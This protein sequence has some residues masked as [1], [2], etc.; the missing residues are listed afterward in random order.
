MIARC[1]LKR[2]RNGKNEKSVIIRNAT[3]LLDKNEISVDEF[4]DNIAK[5][6]SNEKNTNSQHVFSYSS[7]EE[8]E[9]DIDAE[10]PSTTQPPP[11][12]SRTDSINLCRICRT[13]ESNVIAFPCSHAVHC[14]D[15][16]TK[17]VLTDDKYC[18]EC[19]VDVKNVYKFN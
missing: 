18:V 11:K 12:R 19:F 9:D 10:S 5:F 16:W 1:V 3:E 4:L 13:N 15:C 8:E 2:K 17:K 6:K 14:F 7:G